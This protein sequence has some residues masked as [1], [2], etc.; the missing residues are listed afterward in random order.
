MKHAQLKT[1]EDCM[2]TRIPVCRCKAP[3][4]RVTLIWSE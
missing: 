1:P 4:P 2:L 3:K